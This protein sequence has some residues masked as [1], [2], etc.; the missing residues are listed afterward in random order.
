[1]SPGCEMSYLHRARTPCVQAS[2]M[3]GIVSS[4][5]APISPGS[6]V[7]R[8]NLIS[9]LFRQSEGRKSESVALRVRKVAHGLPAIECASGIRML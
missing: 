3:G 1:M 9:T 8:N 7:S 6:L 4:L 2:R 5:G